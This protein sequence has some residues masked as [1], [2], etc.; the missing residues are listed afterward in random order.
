MIIIIAGGTG[1]FGSRIVRR[2][3]E[4]GLDPLVASRSPSVDLQ[5]DVEDP[6]SIAGTLAEGDLVIDAVGP[7]Q[8]RSAALIDGAIE[9]GFHLVDLADSVSYVRAVFDRER[10]ISERDIQVLRQV[11][12]GVYET[13]P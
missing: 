1:F 8:E 4:R 7:F 13:Y 9:H 12:G 11:D 10:Q 3:S 6:A 2:L 5:L